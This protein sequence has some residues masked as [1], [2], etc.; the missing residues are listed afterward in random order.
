MNFT[1]PHTHTST[2]DP[3]H[4]PDFE[5]LRLLVPRVENFLN[6]WATRLVQ[7]L[8]QVPAFRAVDRVLGSS[9]LTI[10]DESA[11]AA[12][13]AWIC[14]DCTVQGLTASY[15]RYSTASEG[16]LEDREQSEQYCRAEADFS[17]RTVSSMP[18]MFREKRDGVLKPMI[19]LR[20]LLP[21]AIQS[22]RRTTSGQKNAVRS[23][24][25]N[26]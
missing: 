22:S 4:Q 13:L 20:W 1:L 3:A 6:N 7:S 5:R 21:L 10:L 16:L 12:F 9:R 26:L 18:L 19:T 14:E 24:R 11:Q 25:N 15:T 2:G 8:M 17:C 23:Q